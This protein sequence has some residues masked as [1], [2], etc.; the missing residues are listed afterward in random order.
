MPAALYLDCGPAGSGK[1]ARLLDRY[2]AVAG[3]GVGTALWLGPTR[4]AVEAVREGLLTG[5][6][7]Y[8]DPHLWTFQDF[9]DELIRVNDPGARPLTNVQRRLLVDEVVAD[10]HAR[11]ELSH[12]QRVADL[13]GF[14]DG[15]L[16]LLTELKRN[17][18]WAEH[19][20][21]AARQIAAGDLGPK[22]QQCI[23]LYAAYQRQLVKHQLYDLEGRVWYARDLLS[24]GRRSP[25]DAVK[26]VFV[27]GFTD[28]TRTQHEILA[29]LGAYVEELWITLPDEPGDARTELFSRPRATFARL[30][31]AAPGEAEPWGV[32][33]SARPAGLLHLERQLFRPLREVQQSG[34]AEGV[35]CIEAPGLLGEARLVA[36]RIKALLVDG[37][38]AEHIL[39][40]MRDLVPYADLLREVFTEYGVP[41]DVEGTEPLLQNPAVSALLRALRLPDE[42]WSFAGVTSLLRSTF[43]RPDWPETRQDPD[44]AQHAEVLL[45]LLGE[46]RNRA[47]YLEAVRRWA[48]QPVP[49]LEDEQAEESRRQ[50][51]HQ[52][53]KRCRPFLQRFFQ[54]WDEMPEQAVLPQ[55]AGWLRRFCAHLGW[56]RAA[57]GCPAERRALERL[58]AELDDWMR[59]EPVLHD[60]PRVLK[61][62]DFHHLLAV[63]AGEAG[64]ARTPR[65]SGRVRVLSAEL[66]RGLSVPYVFV[67]G[68]GE[69]S[70]PR[71]AAPEPIFDEQERQAFKHAGLD[72][73]C[74]GD[75]MPDEM[76][77]FYQLVTR[78]RRELI[79]S[80]PAVDEKG[81]P[82]LASSFLYAV[83]ECFAPGAIP[84]ERRNMLLEGIEKA[85]LLSPAE[86]RVRA[87]AVG[88]VQGLAA[89]LAANLRAASRMARQRFELSDHGP[90][91][92]LLRHPAVVSQLRQ[93]FGPDRVFSPTAL[94]EYIACPFRFFLRHVLHLQPLDEPSEEIESTRR[95]QAFHR[96]LS[97]LHQQL[98][99]ADIHQPTEAV[100]GPV[101]ERLKEAVE[102]CVARAPS[103]AS[104]TLWRLEG[105]RLLR[106]GA[107][108]R[109]HW[110]KFIEPWLPH[111][112]VPRPHFFEVDFGLP[113]AN[114]VPV[115]QALVL[116]A[117][118]VEVRVSGRIDRVDVAELRDGLGFWIVDYKTGNSSHYTA[119]HLREFRRV[120]LTLYALAVERV[121]LAGQQARPLG[122]AYWMVAEKGPKP[123]LPGARSAELT[124]W[125]NSTAGWA[126]VREQLELWITTLVRNIREG[127]FPLK[128]REE[129]CTLTCDYSEICRISQAR[130]AVERKTWQLPLPMA[131]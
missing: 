41:V 99:A 18:I 8:L 107:R 73:P 74:L 94:E 65:G 3:G 80:Y 127:T 24:R 106:L 78:A 119:G 103:P 91:D 52:L 38:P 112:V 33:C 30:A 5:G 21:T 54:A 66:A 15:V 85:R 50:R 56:E 62:K 93:V 34:N 57:A 124:S 97:R 10:L 16:A 2:R 63:L 61:K 26:A 105:Q 28:F 101:L 42:D 125:L 84:V 83:R 17:E 75:R 129:H 20:A 111:E 51:T 115:A 96:A 59:I 95:G 104:K 114:E 90:Y 35:S 6:G 98:K 123:V 116:R 122:L 7:R 31:T 79:L 25:F 11:G 70:F 131:T 58:I 102:E 77:L 4:R 55:F 23:L 100:D 72:F 76:L 40:T 130:P 109:G 64:L 89:D 37:T 12:F 86:H 9:A 27:D 117:G 108:Y 47:A 118:D 29:A 36:R 69:R 53:A 1:T 32:S 39:V 87:A 67:L 120:Q 46:P 128:P 60:R 126:S 110:Q 49:G 88:R 68:L 19:L 113:A 43:F 13:R 82:L 45:R 121:F 44:V 71:L 22:E 14:V 48:E 92:G 81:Q